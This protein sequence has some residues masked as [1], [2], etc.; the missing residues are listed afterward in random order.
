MA[1]NVSNEELASS[2]ILEILPLTSVQWGLHPTSVFQLQA[3]GALPLMP[4]EEGLR[5]NR[6]ATE[7]ALSRE[8][9]LFA[10]NITAKRKTNW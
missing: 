1:P 10:Q 8:E 6:A 2:K 5:S 3:T 9:S 7:L 4:A